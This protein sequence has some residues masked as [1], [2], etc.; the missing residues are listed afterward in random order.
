MQVTPE[1]PFPWRQFI[2]PRYWPTWLGL[3]LLRLL[4][5]LPHPMQLRLGRLLGRLA[6][7]VLKSRV[8]IARTNIRLCFPK[9]SADD[10]EKLLHDHFESI[11][12]GIF[13]TALTW[14][15]A[16]PQLSKRV[17]I[18]GLEHIHKAKEDGKGIVLVTGHFS[19]MELAGHLL[20]T[21]SKMAAMYRPMKNKLMDRLVLRARNRTLTAAFTRDD[22]RAMIKHL[23]KGEAI[24]YAYDQNY[25]LD[26]AIFTPF[27][28]IPAATI[29]TTSR[30]AKLGKAVVMPYFPKRTADGDYIIHVHPPLS[31]FPSGDDEKDT[32]QIN[33]LLEQAILEA[34]E[35]YFWLHRRFKTR[36]EGAPTVY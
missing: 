6:R 34:P 22:T 28:G 33:R 19:T 18:E 9:Y 13:E 7:R 3:G 14:W 16:S 31:N 12:M 26:H 17:H 4:G 23:R 8:H 36:P 15:G 2:H 11:G 29:T 30:F 10:Q 35:Q 1:S 27:F 24:F 5:L 32:Q 20:S 25:G 21:H